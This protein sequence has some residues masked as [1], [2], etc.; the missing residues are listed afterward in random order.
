MESALKIDETGW[1]K[2]VKKR[3]VNQGACRVQWETK[4]IA[5]DGTDQI[6][7]SRFQVFWICGLTS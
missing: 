6:Q 7:N 3:N 4:H 1:Q 2:G 5:H